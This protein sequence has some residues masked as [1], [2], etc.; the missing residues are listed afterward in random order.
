MALQA[1]GRVSRMYRSWGRSEGSQM[2]SSSRLWVK[3]IAFLSG[4]RT[5]GL[6]LLIRPHSNVSMSCCSA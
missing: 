4:W 5:W 1:T 2:L 6:L 3:H